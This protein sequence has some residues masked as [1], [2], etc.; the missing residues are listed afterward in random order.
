MA[1]PDFEID[2]VHI[3]IGNSDNRLTQQE[4]SQYYGQIDLAVRSCADTVH[5]AYASLPTAP[6]QNACWAIV[7]KAK[8]VDML[9][10]VLR[11]IAGGFGQD[12]V[13]WAP[14]PAVE[15]LPGTLGVAPPALTSDAPRRHGREYTEAPGVEEK[16]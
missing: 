15:F 14:C 9:K 10:N 3:A 1:S 11:N 4:W 8:A 6:Y 16:P 2:V 12:S 7:P 5:G 13:A